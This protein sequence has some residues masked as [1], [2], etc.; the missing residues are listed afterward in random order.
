[1]TEITSSGLSRR[2]VLTGA[3]GVAAAA[4][5]VAPAVAGTEAGH[6]SPRSLRRI[7]KVDVHAHYLPADYRQALIDNGQSHPDG[8]PVL[9]TWS[10]AAHLE[11]MDRLGIGTSMLS[12][13]SPGV[14][15]GGDPVT[16]ARRVNESGAETVRA[17]PGR[18]GLFASLPLPDIDASLAEIAY[19]FGE[20][21]ADGVV[22]MTN[23]G[24]TY[25]GDQRFAPV[26]EELNRRRAVVFMH[27]TSPACFAETSL[28]YPRPILEFLLDTTRTV[29]DL[30]LNGTLE[31]NPNLRM[32]VPHA[33]AA[34]SV[35]GDRLAG[36]AGLFPIGGQQPGEI[37][38]IAT[39]QRLYYEVGAGF[40]FPRQF[41]ALL[42][43][44]DANRLLYGT[45][46]PFGGVPGI[47]AN[48]DALL[49]TRLLKDRE[50]RE[51]LRGNAIELFP[52]LRAYGG[53]QN[54]S[55]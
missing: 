40:P 16:W 46:Y 43:L 10:A 42:D 8:F 29:A 41:G 3:L 18:F 33:G 25:L 6:P 21:D 28:G 9:P 1:M 55:R 11:M 30:V 31:A 54:R 32:I 44:V 27:P 17:H 52:R 26:L 35:L 20:L 23:V 37:D 49:S 50:I 19:A 34:L 5:H 39:L 45:D 36:F 22:V 51:V 4:G 13:S 48:A 7:P 2:T 12:V 47:E 53:A 38:V 15:F 24:G 14:T